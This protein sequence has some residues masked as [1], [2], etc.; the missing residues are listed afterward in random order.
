MPV[1]EIPQEDFV[2]D[3]LE[4][5]L[6]V[7]VD[8]TSE[9]CAPCRMVRSEVE[10]LAKDLEGKVRVVKVDIDNSPDVFTHLEITSLPTFM[11]FVDGDAVG[12]VEGVHRRSQLRKFVR[13]HIY[14]GD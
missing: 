13:Q 12:G 6:P 1:R 8:F 10:A 5:T 9:Y 3:V 11:L 14:L 7:L 2:H 4:S